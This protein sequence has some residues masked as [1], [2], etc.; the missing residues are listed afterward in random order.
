MFSFCLLPWGCGV[1]PDGHLGFLEEESCHTCCDESGEELCEDEDDP[2]LG[3]YAGYGIGE[4]PGECH[5]RIREHCAGRGN[6]KTTHQ[7]ANSQPCQFGTVFGKAPYGQDKNERTKEFAEV[8]PF[9]PG[10]SRDCY[11]LRYSLEEHQVA[12]QHAHEATKKLNRDVQEPLIDF[13]A[14][15]SHE[16]QGNCWVEVSATNGTEYFYQD[17]EHKA[18]GNRIHENGKRNACT[19]HIVSQ[20]GRR[21]RG[22]GQKERAKEF[23]S[24]PP[25]KGVI[26]ANHQAGNVRMPT[27]QTLRDFASVTV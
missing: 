4:D 20:N 15:C 23:S 17:K 3:V 1:L 7:H 19:Q 11:Q 27:L 22:H 14:L 18:N 10:Y 25:R 2:V 8:I 5:L 21:D 16:R 9:R 13:H 24:E 12:R 26:H 6:K